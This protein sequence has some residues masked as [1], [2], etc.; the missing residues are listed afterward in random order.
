MSKHSAAQRHKIVGNKEKAGLQAI[1]AFSS[2]FLGLCSLS[3]GSVNAA[4]VDEKVQE[5][6]DSKR[7]DN[8]QDSESLLV[9]GEKIKRS[10]FDTGSSVQV[11]D[12]ERIY[13]H[14]QCVAG[15]RFAAHDPQRGGFGNW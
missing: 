10:I 2:L 15:P 6:A 14:A 11:F 7:K 12:S 1:R 13:F 8:W 9:T 3:V 4:A 5:A